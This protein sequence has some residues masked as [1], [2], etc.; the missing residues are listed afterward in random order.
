MEMDDLDLKKKISFKIWSL[1]TF[2]YVVY[3]NIDDYPYIN[4]MSSVKRLS[5]YI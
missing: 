5:K 1:T 2:F 3:F 4:N